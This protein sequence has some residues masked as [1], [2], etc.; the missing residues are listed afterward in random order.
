M[1]LSELARRTL[2]A[3]VAIPIVLGVIWVGDAAL[4]AL[5]AIAA[6]LAAWEFFRLA[7][8]GEYAPLGATGIG[9]AAVLPLVAHAQ[10]RG[11]VTPSV[12]WAVLAVLAMLAVALVARGPARRPIGAVAVTVLGVVYTGGLLS[13]AYILRYHRFTNYALGAEAGAVL[14]LLPVLLTWT[15]DTGGYFVGRSFGRHK[16]LPSVSPGKTIEGAVGALVLCAIVAWVYMRY[17]LVPYAQ[18]AL[19]PVSAALFGIGVSVAVQIGDLVESLM[20]REVAVKDSSHLVPGHG[21]VLDRLDGMLFALPVAYWLLE[22]MRVYP[23][24]R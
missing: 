20:K 8:R 16:L 12:T 23:V 13:Y 1:A 24:P 7:E 10:R 11:V 2:F 18:L 9:V 15:S 14:L 21:G 3:V 19:T 4:A 22:V 6:A 17:V 5:L